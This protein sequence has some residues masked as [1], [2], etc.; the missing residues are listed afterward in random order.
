MDRISSID[1]AV[2]NEK[3]EMAFYL[4]QASRSENILAKA[5]FETL[6]A[7]EQEHMTVIKRL[8]DKLLKE[9]SWPENVPIEIEG[10]NVKSILEDLWKDSGAASNQTEDDTAAFKKG[11]E[12]EQRA[13]KHY[14]DLANASQNPQEKKFFSCL[15]KMNRSLI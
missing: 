13:A 7:E 14:A 1:L 10:T 11:M 12:N 5:L 15:L 6:A 4:N 3:A 2:E 8:H 9:G